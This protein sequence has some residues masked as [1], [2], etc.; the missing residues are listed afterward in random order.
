MA[1]SNAPK[2]PERELRHLVRVLNTDI[3]GE[4]QVLYALT[5]VKGVSIM[6]ANAV[7]KRANINPQK[8]AGYLSEK[9][10]STIENLIQKPVNAGI[11][12]WLL[13]R[14]ADPETGENGHLITSN[15]DF[16]HEMDIKKMKKVKSYKG[17]R[18]QWGQPVRGQRTKANT[19]KNKGRGSLGV[20]RKKTAAAA[21]PAK[22]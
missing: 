5:K 21:A 18:H 19:R 8:K 2:A 3:R 14:R 11:P 10:V 9:E 7:L 12:T 6:F 20:Q 15:L 4:K 16:T 17:F 1:E 13:N 22:K